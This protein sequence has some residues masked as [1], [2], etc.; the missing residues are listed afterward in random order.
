MSSPRA[1]RP[2]S[3]GRFIP[4]YGQD[5]WI[6]IRGA[7]RANP[8]LLILQGLCQTAP[9]LEPWENDWT[10]V[11]WD[12]PG[13]GS[14]YAKNMGQGTAGLSFDRVTRDAV[15]V[16]EF[17]RQYLGV[18]KIAILATSG[19]TINGLKLVRARPDLFF[20]YIG[21]GQVVNFSRQEALS[22]EL[23]LAQARATGDRAAVAE[24]EAIGAPPYK[25][26]AAVATKDKYANAMFP[27]EQA[28]FAALDPAVLAAMRTP[29]AGA[30]YIAQ[31]LPPFD[32]RAV[33]MAWFEALMPEFAAFD[34]LSLGTRFDVPMFF[35][36]GEQDLHTVTSEVQ[37]YVAEIQALAKV[38]VLL[39]NAGHMSFF[40]RDQMLALLNA[41]VRPLATAPR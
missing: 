29:P 19:G 9:F 6:T 3:E 10:I 33:S 20:A 34:A 1:P 41:H 8:V 18:A 16:A 31:G 37:S 35:F 21:N 32:F 36:Q 7:D 40:L 25:T 4:V 27:A 2:I 28:I 30:N 26:V 23:V 22:Y 11:Q 17:I 15:G 12:P 13:V 5:Q 14:T 24:L 38:L 39:P